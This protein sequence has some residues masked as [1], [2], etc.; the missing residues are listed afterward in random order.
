[1]HRHDSNAFGS[2]FEDG[3]LG[4]VLAFSLDVQLFDETT[5][6]ITLSPFVTTSQIAY[7]VNISEDLISGRTQ[8]EDSMRARRF[9]KLVHRFDD[10]TPIPAAVKIGD[11][12]HRFDDGRKVRFD[13]I[14]DRAEGMKRSHA[15]P[16]SHQQVVR[17][18]EERPPEW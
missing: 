10:R 9:Q 6:R 11:H 18:R 4:A 7:P 17:Y 16:V 5:K 12:L 14:R 8:R 3:S 15:L 1:M 13:V 2:F